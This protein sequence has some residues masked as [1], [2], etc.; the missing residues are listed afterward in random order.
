MNELPP[1]RGRKG[2]AQE[3]WQ[4]TI[5]ATQAQGKQSSSMRSNEAPTKKRTNLRYVPY[6][7]KKDEP[8]T[9]VRDETSTRPRFRVSCKELLS[10]LGI[11]DKLKISKKIDRFLGSRRDVWCD[12]HRAFGHS[13]E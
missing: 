2:R 3:E 12:F 10:M 13:V 6:V 9:K 8:K 4:L 7:A 1:N 11:D 5:E